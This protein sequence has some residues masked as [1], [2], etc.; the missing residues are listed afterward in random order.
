MHAAGRRL[1]AAGARAVVVKGGHRSGGADD[2]YMDP[3][4][5]E[6][7]RAERIATRCNHGT[8]CTFSA[9]I[10]AGLARGLDT[11]DAVR[12][13]KDYLTAAMRAGYEVGAGHSPVNHFHA[14]ILE[15]STTKEG[16]T[17]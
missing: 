16:T 13:A 14:G 5:I 1:L 15:Y 6:W 7:L 10:A 8:G 17:R 9:A 11:L 12:A 2:L 4:R 3:D